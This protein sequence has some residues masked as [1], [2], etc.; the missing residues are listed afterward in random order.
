[1]T[2]SNAKKQCG[3]PTSPTP[4]PGQ[5]TYDKPT[6]LSSDKTSSVFPVKWVIVGIGILLVGYIVF[7]I[8][9]YRAIVKARDTREQNERSG[10][11]DD[12]FDVIRKNSQ[13]E[14]KEKERYSEQIVN[15]SD[16]DEIRLI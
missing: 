11:Y 9:K 1:M 16:K 15:E 12:N 4:K 14:K 10:A 8:K 2:V 3:Q 13:A 5:N 6:E 7:K